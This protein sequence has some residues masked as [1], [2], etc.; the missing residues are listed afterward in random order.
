MSGQG[1]WVPVG[2][3]CGCW[4]PWWDLCTGQAMPGG[5]SRAESGDKELNLGLGAPELRRCGFKAVSVQLL[6]WGDNRS[7]W[8]FSGSSRGVS[9]TLTRPWARP[10]ALQGH[11]WTALPGLPLAFPGPPTR[12][13]PAAA[14]SEQP[15]S[16]PRGP[17]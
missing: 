15:H 10:S 14:L 16:Q 2:S 12:G 4:V 1:P 5:P 13:R 8:V 7:F 6:P 3:P 9:G 17:L 11:G